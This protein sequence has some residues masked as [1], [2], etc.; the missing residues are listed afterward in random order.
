MKTWIVAVA[1]LMAFGSAQAQVTGAVPIRNLKVGTPTTLL[2]TKLA[3]LEQRIKQT[4]EKLAALQAENAALKEQVT[5]QKTSIKALDMVLTDVKA[6]Y[7]NHVHYIGDHRISGFMSASLPGY[8]YPV[9]VL[10][11]QEKEGSPQYSGKPEE[12]K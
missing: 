3:E 8:A 9:K 6:N 5:A 4:E 1:A 12:A 2:D 7:A 11:T 10:T